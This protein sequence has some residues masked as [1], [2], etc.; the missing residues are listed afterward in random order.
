MNDA[1]I[2]HVKH[3]EGFRSTAY[4]CPAGYPTIGYGHRIPTLHYPPVDD[5]EATGWLLTDLSHAQRSALH[6]CPNLS[7][8]RLDA[9]TDL[10]YNVGTDA[11]DGPSALDPT[12]D[13]GV[14]QALRREDWPEAAARF[15]KWCN[16]RN[17]KTGTLEPLPGLVARREVGAR[18]IEQGI[19]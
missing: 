18:W 13:A 16:A 11:L 10:V 3:F 12:D 19:N 4:L 15:R 5:M 2:L 7:G 17:P 1:L 14:I 9:L 6:L 8:P